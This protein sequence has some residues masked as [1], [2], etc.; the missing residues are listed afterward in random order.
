M[1]DEQGRIRVVDYDDPRASKNYV[2]PRLDVHKRW[3]DE[4]HYD[5][6]GEL[7]GWTRIRGDRKEQFAASGLLITATDALPPGGP[8]RQ[9]R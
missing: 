1:Y 8:R 6:G 3:R 5:A 2:D 7:A 4:Y 9:S